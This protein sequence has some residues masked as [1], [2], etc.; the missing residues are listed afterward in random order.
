MNCGELNLS[1]CWDCQN[2]KRFCYSE[3][4]YD[5]LFEAD[6]KDIKSFFLYLTH[7]KSEIDR[8]KII[9]DRYFPQYKNLLEKMMVLG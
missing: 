9:I 5:Y 4:I 2:S 1:N 3:A 6:L 8:E 7:Q